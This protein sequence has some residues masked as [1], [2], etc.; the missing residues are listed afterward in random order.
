[1]TAV[2]NSIVHPTDLS[3]GS[4]DAFAHALRIALTTKSRLYLLHVTVRQD[5]TDEMPF[6][7]VGHAL[8]AWGLMNENEPLTAVCS[9][10]GIEIAKVD[11]A[12]PSTIRGIRA[13][14]DT[15]PANLVVVPT[16]VRQGVAR[17]LH[18]SVA[19]TLAHH[20]KA[21]TLFVPDNVR[22]FVAQAGGRVHLKRVLIP[23]GREMKSTAAISAIMGLAHMLVG[24]GVEERLLHV[25]RRVLQTPHWGLGE[26]RAP[27]ALRHVD[28][29]HPSPV[30]IRHGDVVEKIIDEATE[31]QADMIGMPTMGHHFLDALR[32]TT[33]ERVLRRVLRQAPCPVLAVT[34]RER[35][36]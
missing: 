29:D 2:I 8:A 5:D 19:E 7:R 10:L 22:G 9:R 34:D 35:T 18:G 33:S 28:L 20:A 21:P 12:A 1:M 31:W 14:L 6:L 30:V 26:R 11:L 16:Q 32:G 13:F 36:V 23:V 24:A 25:D 17:W 15:H 3:T 27:Q 4:G